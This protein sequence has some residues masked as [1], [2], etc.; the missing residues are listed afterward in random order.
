MGVEDY[1]LMFTFS[2]VN[3]GSVT[4]GQFSLRIVNQDFALATFIPHIPYT[5]LDVKVLMG[6]L[7]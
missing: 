7:V 6:L 3:I 5:L 4:R 1:G 2:A